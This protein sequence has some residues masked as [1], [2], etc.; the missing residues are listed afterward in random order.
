MSQ[1]QQSDKRGAALALAAE[2]EEI[3]G[4]LAFAAKSR[5]GG[6]VFTVEED[7][8]IL[9]ALKA[10]TPS[11]VVP[12]CGTCHGIASDLGC[13][14]CSPPST[15]PRSGETP[16]TDA[17][18]KGDP[19]DLHGIWTLNQFARQLERELAEVRGV[20]RRSDSENDE[21]RQENGALSTAS[22]TACS[23][24]TA[25]LD[26]LAKIT[27]LSVLCE[28]GAMLTGED[29]RKIEKTAEALSTWYEFQRRTHDTPE[30]FRLAV[31]EA[32]RRA[33]G[34]KAS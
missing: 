16:R 6:R 30:A 7:A 34:G 3:G 26:F 4:G 25:R 9:E 11:H 28:F 31:D 17:F 18:E 21:L 1:E 22:A 10:F 8:L 12:I 23:T 27:N 13:P 24:D 19:G 29:H 14:E 15:T 5:F 33:D 20:L 2:I 32:M